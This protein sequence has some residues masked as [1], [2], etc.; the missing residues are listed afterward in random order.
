MYFNTHSPMGIVESIISVILL[1]LILLTPGA[2]FIF[3]L[4]CRSLIVNDDCYDFHRI[5]GSLF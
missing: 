4:K 2:Y 5:F 1:V 3:S